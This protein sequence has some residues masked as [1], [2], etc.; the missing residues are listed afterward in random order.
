[1]NLGLV[2]CGSWVRRKVEGEGS[3]S[4]KGSDMAA[5]SFGRRQG[6]RDREQPDTL[7][8]SDRSS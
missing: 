2:R 4:L 1:M 7:E 6:D 5:A 8:E 3:D